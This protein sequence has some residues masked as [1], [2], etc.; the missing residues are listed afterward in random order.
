MEINYFPTM[1]EQNKNNIK[2]TWS[3][4]KRAIGNNNDTSSI[5]QS[6]NINNVNITDKTEIAEAF[7]N[8]FSK[9]G[10]ATSQSVPKSKRFYYNDFLKNPLTNSLFL[11]AI[12]TRRVI[13]VAN[14][15][16][17][18]LSTGHDDISTKLLKETIHNIK[19]PITHIINRLFG[20]GTCP[21]KLKIP[22]LIPIY[23]ILNNG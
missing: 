20:T 14:K 16:K 17:P 1:I 22:K 18:K 2:Q 6:F 11:E 19:L 12:G 5:T 15:L 9:I 8:Y 21:N 4:L 23:K 3:V 10:E 13:E 7:N